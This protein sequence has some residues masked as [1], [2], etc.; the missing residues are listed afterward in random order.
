MAMKYCAWFLA[1]LSLGT[2]ACA[3]KEE[4]PTSEPTTEVAAP[5]PEDNRAKTELRLQLERSV[6]QWFKYF[7]EQQFSTAEGIATAIEKHVNEH[8]DD[9]AA[10]AKTASPRFRKVACAA[11]GFSGKDQAVPILA[12]AL[13]DNFEEVVVSALLGLWNL[14]KDG[15]AIPVEAVVPYLGHRD[16]D[17]RSNAAMVLSRAAK[18]GDG[19]LF[20]PLTSSMDDSVDTVRVHAAAAL[21]ALADPGA[22]PFLLKALRDPKPLVR[23][24]SAYALGRIKDVRS[25]PGLIENLDDPDVDASKSIH[26]ALVTITGREIERSKRA[27]QNYW[28]GHEAGK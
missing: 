22:V 11:L 7:Q 18:P 27:W 26:K 9:V 12:E 16:P 4:A 17:V 5:Q 28:D 3:S 20:L 6:D 1:L 23:I 10:D 24:R 14:S 25:V 8:F 2:F 19:V 13:R 15:R 21:G